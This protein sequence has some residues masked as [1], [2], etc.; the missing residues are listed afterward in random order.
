VGRWLDSL[1]A[2]VVHAHPLLRKVRD[3]GLTLLLVQ[4]VNGEPER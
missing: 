1:D 2:E 3:L 4:R